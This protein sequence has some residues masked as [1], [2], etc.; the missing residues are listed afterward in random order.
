MIDIRHFNLIQSFLGEKINKNED[1]NEKE[2]SNKPIDTLNEYI[3]MI[4]NNPL[5]NTD[6]DLP[7][8]DNSGMDKDD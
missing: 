3:N 5:F 1:N 7:S 8:D 6:L 2:T 4:F